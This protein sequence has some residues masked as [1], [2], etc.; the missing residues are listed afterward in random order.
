MRI[1]NCTSQEMPPQ[2]FWPSI[3]WQA[4]TLLRTRNETIVP[5]I[6]RQ[7][8]TASLVPRPSAPRSNF[9][10]GR[11]TE[12]LGTRLIYIQ[13]E[14]Q[15]LILGCTVTKLCL[16]GQL[17][18]SYKTVIA[19]VM[20]F[21][22]GNILLT[23]ALIVSGWSFYNIYATLQLLLSIGEWPHSMWL[24]RLVNLQTHKGLGM[25]LQFTSAN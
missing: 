2:H 17:R 1:D 13:H 24:E 16:L 15:N 5:L 20:H 23:M 6:I 25:R 18:C 7:L 10:M 11:G 19:N 14:F 8:Y 4:K 21:F 22:L 12:G 3:K 9:P